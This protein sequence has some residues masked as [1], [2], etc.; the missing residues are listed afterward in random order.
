MPLMVAD[1][2]TQ[3]NNLTLET[4]ITL[5]LIY[6]ARKSHYKFGQQDVFATGL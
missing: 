1:F 4:S 6:T 5:Q 2:E 3:L